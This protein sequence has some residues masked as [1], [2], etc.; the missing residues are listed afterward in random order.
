MAPLDQ[1]TGLRTRQEAF[2]VL[3]RN[4]ERGDAGG[5]VSCDVDDLARFNETFGYAIADQALQA[6]ARILASPLS[7]RDGRDEA[8]GKEAFRLA[9]EEFLVCL[10]GSDPMTAVAFAE[11]AR[12]EIR[13]VTLD[14]VG[15]SSQARALT[16][17][18]AVA[19]WADGAAPGFHTLMLEL[20]VA[21]YTAEPDV[22]VLV[23]A[24]RG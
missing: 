2:R 16:A 3:E 18:F 20:D 12:S 21:L 11:Q 4:L 9:G 8:G 6:V 7:S 14:L 19:A 24:S 22:V 17:R 13:S 15:G 10:P 1:L 23:D 5:L